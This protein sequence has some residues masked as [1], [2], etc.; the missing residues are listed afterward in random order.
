MGQ[1]LNRRVTSGRCGQGLARHAS[2]YRLAAEDGSDTLAGAD[3][4]FA[5]AVRQ[6]VLGRQQR[7]SDAVHSAAGV[8]GVAAQIDVVQGAGE[9]PLS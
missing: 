9:S 6:D 3:E 1:L 4:G 2:R 7:G 8:V 5:G